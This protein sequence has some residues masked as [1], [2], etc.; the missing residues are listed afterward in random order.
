MTSHEHTE[1]EAN[2][3]LDSEKANVQ[4]PALTD[5]HFS[6]YSDDQRSM[7]S[8]TYSPQPKFNPLQI[9]AGNYCMEEIHRTE[10]FEAILRPAERLCSLPQQEN[11]ATVYAIATA[12]NRDQI[13]YEPVDAG[14]LATVITERGKLSGNEV[15]SISE[16]L[17]AALTWFHEQQMGFSALDASRIFFTSAG[18]LKM[19]A[20][21]TDLRG[22]PLSV[23]ESYYEQDTAAAASILWEC[24]TGEAPGEPRK[25]PPLKLLLPETKPE[26]GVTL[27][28]ALEREKP[29]PSLQE[30]NSLIQNHFSEQSV[31]LLASA[32]P[33]VRGRLP[34]RRPSLQPKKR[35]WSNNLKSRRVLAT[36]L[37][38]ALLGAGGYIVSVKSEDGG[39]EQVSALNSVTS[40]EVS[41]PTGSSMI[42]SA[43]PE[44]EPSPELILRD[45][46]N[47]RNE[48]LAQKNTKNIT[49]YAV[50][51]SDLS[52]QDAELI[53]QDSAGDLANM[54]LNLDNAKTLDLSENKI[55]LKA[56]VSTTAPESISSANLQAPGAVIEGNIVKQTV[57]FALEEQDGF[58]KIS[59]V[60]TSKDQ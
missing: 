18:K 51:D 58:W 39:A 52:H 43:S 23:A 7:W 9:P 22:K 42:P 19:L 15:A 25:R 45:L 38:A 53:E 24:L 28:H 55:K 36:C 1:P 4:K 10:N 11:I 12:G 2:G 21:D 6:M 33:S 32:H 14:S 35:S 34:A 56:Q 54:P 29:Q 59:R 57:T 27:E 16:G 5:L 60:E 44:T 31:D 8:A 50:S 20:P 37:L 46:L 30:I 3:I 47:Q 48:T 40:A 41:S 17:T 26:L 13:W 49:A